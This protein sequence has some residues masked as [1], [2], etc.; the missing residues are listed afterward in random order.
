MM[1]ILAEKIQ[2]GRLCHLIRN[3]LDA[4]YFEYWK[5][6]RTLS[7]VP[8][9][10]VLS[11]LLSNI[12]LDKL[13]TYVETTLIPRYTRGERRKHNKEHA[14]LMKQA[15]RLQQ[16]GQKEAT[17]I[18][19]KPIRQLPPIAPHTPPYHPLPHLPAPH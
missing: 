18:L 5:L 12:L 11:P 16:R 1:S 13:D 15:N 9:G 7:G 10:S 19:T 14:R 17:R 2:D 8:Q 3:L 4:G 6:K